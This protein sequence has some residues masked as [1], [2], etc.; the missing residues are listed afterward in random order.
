MTPTRLLSRRSR[1]LAWLLVGVTGLPAVSLGWLGFQFL[2]QE[3]TL[4]AQRKV[5][6]Q[7]A[8]LAAVVGGFERSLADVTRSF[9]GGP[10]AD[11]VARL[12]ITDDG[13]DADPPNR[14]LWL[15][16]RGPSSLYATR[17]FDDAERREFQGRQ[18]EALALY[19]RQARSSE[20]HLA[21][22]ALLRIARVHR[23]QRQWDQALAVY[24]ELA[25]SDGEIIDGAPASL[26]ARRAASAVL[27]EVGRTTELR[28][29]AA[30][31]ESDL[32][33]GRWRIDRPTWELTVAD[34]ERW[35]GRPVSV[36]VERRLFSAVADH[37]WPRR[38]GAP[39]REV[40]AT[41]E[42]GVTVVRQVRDD[43]TVV[44]AISGG[45]VQDW[46]DRAGT[47]AP[48][49]PPVA[50][51]GPAGSPGDRRLPG[52]DATTAT[53]ATT[54]LPWTITV[55]RGED[56]VLAAAARTRQRL[57]A[58]ALA[59]V[60]LLVGGGGYLLWRVVEREMA[61]ARQQTE[62]VA[63]VS[64]ELRTP[65]TSLRH[66]TELLAE[67]DGLPPAQRAAFY[68]ALG[69]N[70]ERL[71]R[72][73]ES[74]LDFAR[75]QSGRAPY[76]PQPID[77]GALASEVVEQFRKQQLDG[78]VVLEV[79]LPAQAAQIRADRASLA[80]ALWNLLDNAM[81]YSP[82]GSRISVSVEARGSSVAIAVRD[83]GPGVPA[84]ER[85]EIFKR[86]VRG[87]DAQRLGVKGT[88]LG[89]AMAS[90]IIATH[91]GRIELDSEEGAGS[92]F[93]LVLPAMS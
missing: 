90:H 45:V 69:R 54:G 57:L 70:T 46:A 33:A 74:L 32:L 44:L 62:F 61:V 39:Q 50:V 92:T 89:L 28:I 72:L 47:L 88:G 23:G 37:E 12:T 73:V 11:G 68:G 24:G 49:R 9:G 3:R 25:R 13:I 64:H 67:D 31:I 59:A 63:A 87:A 77:A 60:L 40:V 22:G 86:F 38:H 53:A 93:R 91:G 75:M 41:A 4:Q 26:L 76:E 14:V 20:R 65:L 17:A 43:Q 71:H 19:R 16:Q 58:A 10:V 30:A 80:S 55:G 52:G 66:V 1:T 85:S 34:L 8:A 21:T 18:T 56:P 51:V 81:K 6:R 35:A 78:S 5:E 82:A 2:Q 79:D 15:P 84:H 48:G 36:S 7:Q 42:G 27:E 83:S 29:S